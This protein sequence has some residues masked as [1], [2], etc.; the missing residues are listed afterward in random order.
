MGCGGFRNDDWDR[1]ECVGGNVMLDG[2]CCRPEEVGKIWNDPVEAHL[3]LVW[4]MR[5]SDAQFPPKLPMS[6]S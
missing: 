6:A 3:L 1:S 4:V 2:D 5:W